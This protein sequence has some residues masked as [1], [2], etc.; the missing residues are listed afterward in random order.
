MVSLRNGRVVATPPARQRSPRRPKPMNESNKIGFST[1]IDQ[2][3]QTHIINH[4]ISG[5]NRV[6]E[7][8][9]PPILT[10]EQDNNASVDTNNSLPP[11][12]SSNSVKYVYGFIA[13]LL[14]SILFAQIFLGPPTVGFESG[15]L[16]SFSTA[17]TFSFTQEPSNVQFEQADLEQKQFDPSDHLSPTPGG[18]DSISEPTPRPVNSISEPTPGPVNSISEP[19]HVYIEQQSSGPESLPPSP[20]YNLDQLTVRRKIVNQ[21]PSQFKIIF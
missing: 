8:P 1:K 9:G 20:E 6:D 18:V 7:T 16:A 14:S 3:V 17:R 5:P 4:I 19:T 12:Q 11:K 2:D 10:V 13:F 15:L 21:I